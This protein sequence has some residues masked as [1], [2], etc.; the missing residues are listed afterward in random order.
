MGIPA[1]S[2]DTTSNNYRHHSEGLRVNQT[3]NQ[4]RIRAPIAGERITPEQLAYYRNQSAKRTPTTPGDADHKR[5]IESYQNYIRQLD[6]SIAILICAGHHSAWDYGYNFFKTSLKMLK[7]DFK[8]QALA[9][10]AG[11]GL[12][13]SGKQAKGFLED[14]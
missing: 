8:Q 12:A 4:Q 3:I 2:Q 14:E 6:E 1:S 10:A 11:I 9:V 7:Y 13:L 5:V